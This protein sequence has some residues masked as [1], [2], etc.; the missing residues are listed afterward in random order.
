MKSVFHTLFFFIFCVSNAQIPTYY[1]S[2]NLSLKGDALKSELATLITNTHTTDLIYSPQ[3]WDVL[4]DADVDPTNSNKILLIYGWNDTDLIKNNDLTRDRNASCHSANCENKWVRE[5]VFP[6][7]K[8]TPNL[9][10]EGPG[11]DAHH[12]R[13]ADYDRN[14]LR[15]NFKFIANPTSYITYSRVIQQNGIEYFYPGNQWKGDIARMIMYMYVRYGNR[16][17]PINV[18]HGATSFSMNGDMPNI[19]LQWNAEDPVSAHE[20]NR[21]ET[22]YNAQGNRNPFIDNPYLATLIWN[23]PA[24]E[25]KWNSLTVANENLNMVKVYPTYTSDIVNI[26]NNSEN[27]SYKI[28]DVSNKLIE[29]GKNKNKINVSHYANGI[30]FLN[31]SIENQSKTFKFIKK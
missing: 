30:Y 4:K 22:I 2:I 18:G 6:R 5:H 26:E 13:A 28:F 15:S 1:Q 10:F 9:E 12:L 7:S 8:G 29:Q 17:Q 14:S 3:V 11:A 19:F 20:I 16:C 25:N 23:G 27:Y 24:A 31:I 21:N